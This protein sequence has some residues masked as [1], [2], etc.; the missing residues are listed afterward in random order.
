MSP[1]ELLYIEDALGHEVM[2]Q[3]CEPA[4]GYGIKK[5]R[6]GALQQTPAEL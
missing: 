1:K 3:F 5:F 2:H 4:A 6:T